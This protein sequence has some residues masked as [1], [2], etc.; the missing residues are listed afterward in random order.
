[1]RASAANLAKVGLKRRRKPLKAVF[2]GFA[3][4]VA[5]EDSF[6]RFLPARKRRQT[7]FTDLSLLGSGDKPFLA[8]SACSEAAK[9]AP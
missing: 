1:V 9:N 2:S 6:S 5:A 4:P 7:V 3:C 8:A